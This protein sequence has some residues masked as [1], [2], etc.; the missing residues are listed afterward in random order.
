M[1][2]NNRFVLSLLLFSILNPTN[3][4]SLPK[5]K[6]RLAQV[7]ELLSTVKKYYAIIQSNSNR[8]KKSD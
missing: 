5:S 7:A 6:S 4:I 3:I 8:F 2:T 1:T